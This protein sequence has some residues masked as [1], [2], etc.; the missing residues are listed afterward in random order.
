MRTD[1]RV[2]GLAASLPR[3]GKA[4]A[5]PVFFLYGLEFTPSLLA[6]GA[7]FSITGLIQMVMQV[8]YG[9]LVDKWGGRKVFLL[10]LALFSAGSFITGA[11][12]D[13]GSLFVG[14]AVQGLGVVAT[15]AM[16]LA[17]FSGDLD[18][19]AKNMSVL[20]FLTGVAFIAG[21]AL[22]PAVFFLAGGRFLFF[23][24]GSLGVVSFADVLLFME[25]S[26]TLSD[27]SGEVFSRRGDLSLLPWRVILSGLS[28]RASLS[29]VILS[30]PV[31]IGS[32][33][34][35][36][37]YWLFVLPVFLM[38]LLLTWASHRLVAGM[39][40]SAS[41]SASAILLLGGG[42]LLP[43]GILPVAMFGVG[44][45]FAG[46][47]LLDPIVASALSFR[48]PDRLLGTSSGAY[49]MARYGGDVLAGLLAAAVYMS[50]TTLFVSL[51][52]G[53]GMTLLLLHSRKRI[54]EVPREVLA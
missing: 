35:D 27:Q 7:A 49:N 29:L 47:G 41:L 34:G 28:L 33:V 46:A 26:P 17:G 24:V 38:G 9:R 52:V 51:A 10:S 25:S 19:K 22:G 40:L 13:V 53:G 37:R 2:V 6:V 23:L 4:M 16:A 45:F 48:T 18:S 32:L 31:I 36:D 14:R 44:L 39:G 12:W 50:R 20:S 5:L 8:P 21:A 43:T 30:L 3:L 42:L 54:H 15:P 11:A 1:A